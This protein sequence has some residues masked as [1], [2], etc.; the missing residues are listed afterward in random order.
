MGGIMTHKD[1]RQW[2]KSLK[3]SQKDAAEALG[4]KRR[5]VQYYEK[6][7]RDGEKIEIPKTV[8]L[9]CYALA[10]GI[11]DYFGTDRPPQLAPLPTSDADKPKEKSKEVN[12]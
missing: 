12:D 1:F 3:L 11:S 9:A 6:G 8:R 5:V 4:L 2:R 7:E 10:Q